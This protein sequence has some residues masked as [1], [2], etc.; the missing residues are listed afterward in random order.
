MST[1]RGS[2]FSNEVEYRVISPG[3]TWSWNGFGSDFQVGQ[4]L[5]FVDSNYSHYDN[6]S[7]Y[8]FRDAIGNQFWWALKDD[9]PLEKWREVFEPIE[10][11]G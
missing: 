8:I 2:P 7:A 6:C 4:V 5:R 11:S 3:D 1:W 9:D 10:R